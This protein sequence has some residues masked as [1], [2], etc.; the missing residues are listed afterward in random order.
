MCVGGGKIGGFV[1]YDVSVGWWWW[2]GLCF[3]I[4]GF[5]WLFFRWMCMFVCWCWNELISLVKLWF[6]CCVLLCDVFFVVCWV[7]GIWLCWWWDWSRNI[8]LFVV[9][10]CDMVLCFIG[11]WVW[12]LLFL[13]IIGRLVICWVWWICRLCDGCL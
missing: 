6:V 8:F 9:C 13:L 7:D 1:F 11:C 10:V 5:C 3:W 2:C 12:V 4:F